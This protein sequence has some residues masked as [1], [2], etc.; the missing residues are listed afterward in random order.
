MNGSKLDINSIKLKEVGIS[1]FS[2]IASNRLILKM[3]NTQKLERKKILLI[4]T[5]VNE[6]RPGA[7]QDKSVAHGIFAVCKKNSGAVKS[8]RLID[9]SFIFV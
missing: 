7:V 6:I 8:I 4:L 1:F 5:T 9:F 2:F 3:R